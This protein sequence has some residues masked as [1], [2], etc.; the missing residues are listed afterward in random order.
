[1]S[2][3]E[4]GG[5][6]GPPEGAEPAPSGIRMRK[7]LGAAGIIIGSGLII[8]MPFLDSL[9]G[10][11]VSGAI[12]AQDIGTL[13][14]FVILLSGVLLY[15]GS[16]ISHMEH[17]HRGLERRLEGLLEGSGK[18]P[19]AGPG[20]VPESPVEKEATTPD[21]SAA[22][23]GP[24]FAP[25]EKA[26]ETVEP[27]PAAGAAAGTAPESPP[28]A[29]EKMEET[30]AV[31]PPAQPI[32]PE[33]AQAV[34]AT[35]TDCPV[36][37]N[38]LTGGVCRHCITS[39]AIQNAYQELSRTQELGVWVDETAGLLASAR[40]S[41]E[42]KDYLQAG[43]YVRS[44]K[45]LL[46]ISAKTYFA[47]RSAVEKAESE[48]RKLEESGIDTTELA[49]KLS[50][51]RSTI[52]GGDYQEAKRLLDEE[53]STASDL[54]LPYF[55]RPAAASAVGQAAGGQPQPKPWAQKQPVRFPEKPP[56]TAMAPPEE[57]APA[58]AGPVTGPESI[59]PS[60]AAA[61]SPTPAEEPPAPSQ[62]AVPKFS[63]GI[64]ACPNCGRK[65]MSGWKK[66]PH[67]LAVLR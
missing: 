27:L 51:V 56:A 57:P 31:P 34:P 32:L 29:E 44:S 65:T 20:S 10:V 39:A 45:Y 40:D 1:M 18:E 62:K 6:S 12:S 61:P 13:A 42:E 5:T 47:L 50:A 4:I 15:L 66:C 58:A 52:V 36:C 38:E 2:P 48:R 25:A 14:G 23:Q 19:E 33:T 8:V 22:K 26:P 55:Q 35:G 11:S 60:E 46:E 9:N 37:G 30:V 3:P 64:T 16:V 21:H 24:A 54:S 28:A 43:E 7:T 49:S 59:P 53:R 67:C 41:L 63:S 17:R